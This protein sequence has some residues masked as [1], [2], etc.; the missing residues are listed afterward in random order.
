MKLGI[1]LLQ[2]SARV[3]M[4]RLREKSSEPGHAGRARQTGPETRVEEC[5]TLLLLLNVSP[6]SPHHPNN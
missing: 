1:A 2:R 3:K 6:R 4:A 5:L